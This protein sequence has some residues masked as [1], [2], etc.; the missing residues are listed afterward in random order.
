M[1][2]TF[3]AL[4]VIYSSGEVLWIP[5]ARLTSMCKLD[6]TYFPFDV[7]ECKIKIGSWTYDGNQV[8][9]MYGQLFLK[10]GVALITP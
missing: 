1:L 2:H 4:A 5:P 7:Q 6:M 8:G 3:D 10:L 9:Y